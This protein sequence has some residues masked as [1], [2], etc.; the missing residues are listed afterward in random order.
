MTFFS[1]YNETCTSPF[2]IGIN[3]FSPTVELYLLQEVHNPKRHPLV[4]KTRMGRRERIWSESNSQ[5]VT[6]PS[7]GITADLH[8]TL[9]PLVVL[10]RFAAP[11]VPAR[12]PQANIGTESCKACMWV[13][14]VVGGCFRF[15]DAMRHSMRRTHA[16]V[17]WALS[18]YAQ[19]ISRSTHRRTIPDSVEKIANELK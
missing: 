15:H 3:Q 6:V 5:H 8:A 19:P 4:R 13:R 11:K 2:I 14:I 18:G 1:K 7:L 10:H 12:P 16:W 9:S 17:K